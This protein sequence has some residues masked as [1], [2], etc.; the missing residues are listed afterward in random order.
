MLKR[1]KMNY[2]LTI[3]HKIT[4]IL[5]ENIGENLWDMGQGKM[6]VDVTPRA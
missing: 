1:V 6:F 2:Y 4:K 5:E 3:K